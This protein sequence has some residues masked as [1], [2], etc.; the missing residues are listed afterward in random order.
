VAD[1]PTEDPVLTS[2]VTDISYIDGAG[3]TQTMDPTDYEVDATEAP[4]KVRPL[5][6][7]QWPDTR[8]VWNAVTLQYYVGWAAADV[9]AGLKQAIL[10]LVSQMYE[11]RT[12]EITG[13][14]VAKVSFAV[15]ALIAPYRLV[16]L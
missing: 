3:A 16:R 5:F 6:Q 2:P 1:L 9:P 7:T 11:Q 4:G 15:E 12:P 14:I 10:L 13:T 8:S